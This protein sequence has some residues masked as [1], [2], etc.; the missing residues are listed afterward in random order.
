MARYQITSPDGQKYEITAPD[1]ASQEQ[2]M[3]YARQQFESAKPSNAGVALSSLN[4]GAAAI[5][6]S[7]ADIGPNVM[8]L[9]KAAVGFPL[10]A[11]GR[12]DLAEKIGATDMLEPVSPARRAM[13]FAG[14]GQVKP[15]NATQRRIDYVAQALPSVM[16]S[17]GVGLAK[18]A[19]LT[20]ISGMATGE[21]QEQ[22]GSSIGA[23]LAGMLAPMGAQA[24]A[25]TVARGLPVIRQP[26]TASGRELMVGDFLRGNMSGIDPKAA[27]AARKPL[28]SGSKPTTAQLT[29]EAGDKRLL[30]YEKQLAQDTATRQ[31]FDD[32][33]A[34]NRDARAGQMRRV[35]P[36]DE[37]AAVVQQKIRDDVARQQAAAD[38]QKANA[39]GSRDWAMGQAGQQ[40]GDLQAGQQ[41][42]SVYDD[43][44]AQLRQQN[45]LNYDI[46]PFN[47]VTGLSV[48]T[49]RIGQ[50]VD[51]VYAG[52]TKAAPGSVRESLGIVS[53][54]ATHPSIAAPQKTQK[55]VAAKYGTNTVNPQTDDILTAIA[56]RGGLSREQA[57]QFGID[58]AELN[59]RAGQ[60]KPV[61]PK[62]GGVPFDRMAE[63]LSQDG[64]PV[65]ADGGYSPYALADAL[66]EAMRGRRVLTPQGHEFDMA[67]S[68]W[69]Q[70]KGPVFGDDLRPLETGDLQM[71]YRQMKVAASRI[72][73]LERQSMMSGDRQ[74]AMAL[75]QIKQAMRQS[76]DDAVELGRVTPDIADAYR[77]ATQQYAQYASR[78]KEGVAGNLRYRNTER[79]I[80]LETVPKAFL[81][82]GEEAFRSFQRS[83]GPD[84]TATA[85]AQDWLSTQW[86]NSVMTAD[87]RM[88][89]NWKE[90]SAKWMRDNADVL[91]AFPGLRQRVEYAIAKAG[92]ADALA[93]RL[94]AEMKRLGTGTAAK[95]F[96]RELN[97]ENSFAAFVKSPNRDRE[98][99]LMIAIAKRDPEFRRAVAG[100]MRDHLQAMPDAKFVKFMGA[101]KNAELIRDLFGDKMLKQFQKVSADARR[102]MLRTEAN[103]AAGSDTGANLAARRAMEM[104]SGYLPGAG[105]LRAVAGRV[106]DKAMG[107]MND[108][109]VRAFLNPEDALRM[110]NRSSATPDFLET[111]IAEF[112]R[113]GMT[114]KEA[115]QRA[116]LV[117]A[118]QQ[119]NEERK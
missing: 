55:P 51:D 41:L 72:G 70:N 84:P 102:D 92:T 111:M 77:H 21:A 116:M 68:D 29:A 50:I 97:P 49:Q 57:Q 13:E 46:D 96:L 105:V 33:Y 73:E 52:V 53:Q 11:A 91:D 82:S 99:A 4:K 39:A 63:E 90:S 118:I 36:V 12:V 1:N 114:A 106:V 44:D 2:V 104:I 67:M 113:A 115:E 40:V 37:G 80:K 27:L 103:K 16:L 43:I 76:M 28:V 108:T 117:Q 45:S 79:N 100:A 10:A 109:K 48:P 17:P 5:L 107:G 14:A 69:N 31:Q 75:G 60:G 32:R 74:A 59:K 66:D 64:Y 110:V 42:A 7:V 83:I 15:A 71:S 47:S 94:D 30:G 81:Q 22:T 101:S 38:A 18:N 3:S 65:M 26:F 62:S 8:N 61:F 78:M 89:G 86:R 34:A 93:V 112:R 24:V 54:I 95:H 6:D 56:K 9:A 23:L 19:A 58:P 35:A 85:T 87:G 25:G 88:K 119:Q 20:S 98:S